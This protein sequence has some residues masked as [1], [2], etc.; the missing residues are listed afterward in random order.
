[1]T[2]LPLLLADPS[3]NLRYLV[4]RE[5][6]DRPEKDSEVV[7]LSRM[8][9]EDPLVSEL[10]ELQ[11][12]DGS[13]NTLGGTQKSGRMNSTIYALSRLGYLGYSV[14]FP[15]VS[16]GAE[17][18]F[19]RQGEDGS[20]PLGG[21]AIDEE[22]G[23]SM[24]PLQTAL[25]LRALAACGYATDPRSERAYAWLL[26]KRLPEGVWPSGIAA[27]NYAGVAGYRRLAHS[28]WGCRTNTT[29]ALECLSLHPERKD[30]EGTRKALDLLLGRETRERTYLGFEVARLLGTEH[31]GGIFTHYARF[32]L[33]QIL[34]LSWRVGASAADERVGD[35]ISGVRE[36]QGSQG[37]WQY[38][39]SPY[40]SRWVT[41]DVLRSLL[42]L[43]REIE[44]ISTEPRTPFSAYGKKEM[45]F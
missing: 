41:F 20:W 2:W 45:R 4:L 17:F 38:L 19:S 34:S 27:G 33:A 9:A 13:W 3:P 6:M 8:R 42:R 28:R 5:L 14:D 21:Y 37:L 10:L 30:D 22:M 40:L 1:M 35:M 39:P 7:E 16:K 12:L 26:E 29:G 15:A 36:M 18:L 25:P 11:K 31:I 44:W 43:D 32:D 23:Y 24:I